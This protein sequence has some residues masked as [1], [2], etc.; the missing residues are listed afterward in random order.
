MRILSQ[1]F[2]AHQSTDSV[3]TPFKGLRAHPIKVIKMDSRRE[4]FNKKILREVAQS[5][6]MTSD[7]S[8]TSLLTSDG[9]FH[10]AF[11]HL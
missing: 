1:V 5:S 11:V 3:L 4:G 2:R 7:E 8:L 10:V 9:A 6:T